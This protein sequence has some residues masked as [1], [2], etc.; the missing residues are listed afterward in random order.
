MGAIVAHLARYPQLY[1][2]LWILPFVD[3]GYV[4]NLSTPVHI[5]VDNYGVVAGYFYPQL[6]PQMWISCGYLT[7]YC[8]QIVIR[9]MVPY[10]VLPMVMRVVWPYGRTPKRP[11]RDHP[12]ARVGVRVRSLIANSIT[13]AKSSRAVI[14][15][16]AR[17][18]DSIWRARDNSV[19]PQS[20][21]FP[22]P[23]L[24]RYW[25]VVCEFNSVN[26]C[27]LALRCGIAI[28]WSILLNG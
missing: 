21:R 6:Y 25:Y 27:R 15:Y 8:Y 17:V 28:M 7:P 23:G 22:N 24:C 26:D 10:V 9:E 13:T 16:S 18:G 5:S 2:H 4:D 12:R 20:M 14:V 19:P 11:R 3:C 1:P